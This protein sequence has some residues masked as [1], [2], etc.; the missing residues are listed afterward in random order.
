MTRNS[1]HVT[2]PPYVATQSP[3]ELVGQ[4]VWQA[5]TILQE[6]MMELYAGLLLVAIGIGY[7]VA[8]S[9][10][11]R[12]TARIVK[13]ATTG[14]R[15]RPKNT[16]RNKQKDSSGSKAPGSRGKSAGRSLNRSA[17]AGGSIQKPW[18]W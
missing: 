15:S 17:L 11:S 14:N 12:Y 2:P 13:H 1:G 18:G 8:R 3:K 7:L 16:L 9:M 5:M 10:Q 6:F 4:M